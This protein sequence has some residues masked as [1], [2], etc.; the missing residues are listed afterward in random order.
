[1]AKQICTLLAAFIFLLSSTMA[2]ALSSSDI[3]K[4][5]KSMT[6]LAPYFQELE[7]MEE[8]IHDF[9]M[10]PDADMSD[11]MTMEK[12]VQEML[13]SV[14][15]NRSM[16]GIIRNSGFDSTQQ[17]ADVGSKVIQAM[18]AIEVGSQES[19]MN[20]EM[21]ET[22]AEIDASPDLSPEM[23]ATIKAQI[24][25]AMHQM[26]SLYQAPESDIKAVTPYMSQLKSV[27]D[28]E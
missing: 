14:S 17:W 24:K 1:M 3:Q 21:Q 16:Q 9:S 28:W 26:E 7:E 20:R 18:L 19:E 10:A 15:G 8:D 4:F 12:M 2:L 6:E 22:L 23:K 25:A 27:L 11:V 13:S 5:I